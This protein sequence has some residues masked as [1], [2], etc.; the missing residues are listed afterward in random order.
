MYIHVYIYIYT[1][2]LYGN[3]REQAEENVRKQFSTN[4]HRKLVLFLQK[5][6]KVSGDLRES[7]GE[8]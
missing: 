7:T 3:L 4:T 8:M 6:P 5:S 1:Y 2:I